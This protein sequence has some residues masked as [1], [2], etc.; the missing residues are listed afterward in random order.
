M[1]ELK[2]KGCICEHATEYYYIIPFDVVLYI[3]QHVLDYRRD[4]I[5]L[6][7]PRQPSMN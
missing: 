2:N 4:R 3:I 1:F 6:P 5:N 7:P